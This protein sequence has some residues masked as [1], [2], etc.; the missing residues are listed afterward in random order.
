M[1]MK[2][3]ILVL[4]SILSTHVSASVVHDSSDQLNKMATPDRADK[5]HKFEDTDK[6][7]GKSDTDLSDH[8]SSLQNFKIDDHRNFHAYNKGYK[9]LAIATLSSPSQIHVSSVPV[10]AAVWL[11]ISGLV[12][13]ISFTSRKKSKK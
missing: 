2:I 9:G 13:M 3:F 12:G 7:Q 4:V 10:P 11:F 1:K 8:F 5:T 6:E